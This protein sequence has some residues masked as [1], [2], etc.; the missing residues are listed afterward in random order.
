MIN[1]YIWG[2]GKRPRHTSSTPQGGTEEPPPEPPGSCLFTDVY[3][4]GVRASSQ[5]GISYGATVHH[6]E[7]PPPSIL[8]VASDPGNPRSGFALQAA[9]GT[10][11]TDGAWNIE[12]HMNLP[13]LTELYVEQ[14]IYVEPDF[15]QLNS[16]SSDNNKMLRA[17]D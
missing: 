4:G 7:L 1:R 10:G 13:G 9:F 6:P 16:P 2:K 3:T 14:T 17:W 15:D 12:Q 8:S 5:N 11:P